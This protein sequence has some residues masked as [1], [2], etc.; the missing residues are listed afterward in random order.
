MLYRLV[1]CCIVLC[2]TILRCA[3]PSCGVLCCTVLCCV[4]LWCNSECFQGGKGPCCRLRGALSRCLPGLLNVAF[5]ASRSPINTPGDQ[6]PGNPAVQSGR[7]PPKHWLGGPK[8][9]E[10]LCCTLN[11]D[12]RMKLGIFCLW[13]MK[14]TLLVPMGRVAGPPANLRHTSYSFILML[15]PG[16]TSNCAPWLL[17]HA[18][19]NCAG[20]VE[21]G[22]R[23]V[24]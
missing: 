18:S 20:K 21:W 3:V 1:L 13:L 10:R 5:A 15:L 23:L 11:N 19:G 12:E 2:R 24:P 4:V 17:L 6:G 7:H 16:G 14:S 9:R 8:K 22:E